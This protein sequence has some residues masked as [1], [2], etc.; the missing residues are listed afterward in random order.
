MMLRSDEA[1]WERVRTQPRP[2]RSQPHARGIGVRRAQ[3]IVSPS[4]ELVSVWDMWQ[5]RNAE[6]GQEWQL[7]HP[8]VVE[9]E[10]VLQVVGHDPVPMPSAVMAG[11]FERVT[12]LTLPLCPDLRGSGG[13]DGTM[14][15][16][17]VVGDLFSGWRF[18]WWSESPKQWRSL[19]DLAGEMYLAFT[20]A[21][22][23]SGA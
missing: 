17:E 20:S 7:I 22:A 18:Q 2:A 3:L 13:L 15:E 4:F 12:A 9:S 11:Y 6:R 1:D 16:L 5:M 10:P 21:A 19:V 8:R 23:A 14:Y